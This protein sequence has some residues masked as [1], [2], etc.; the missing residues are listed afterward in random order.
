MV[1]IPILGAR[2]QRYQLYGNPHQ[3]TSA[4]T[5]ERGHVLCYTLI[6]L[7]LGLHCRRHSSQRWAMPRSSISALR[8]NAVATAQHRLVTSFSES[9]VAVK[10]RCNDVLRVA[11]TEGWSIR[12]PRSSRVVLQNA[13]EHQAADHHRDY[14]PGPVV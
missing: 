14:S 11:S 12:S 1:W 3:E 4:G 8:S 7:E 10:P 5:P 2:L 9:R 13:T 6:T